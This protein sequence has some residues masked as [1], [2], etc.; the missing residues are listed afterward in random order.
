L[1]EQVGKKLGEQLFDVLFTNKPAK[2]AIQM[3][4]FLHGQY[5]SRVAGRVRADAG[6]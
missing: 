2:P 3:A 5:E 6:L 4:S 1:A